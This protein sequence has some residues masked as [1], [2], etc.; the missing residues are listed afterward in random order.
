VRRRFFRDSA[1][2]GIASF[3]SRGISVLLVPVYTRLLAPSDY[4]AIDVLTVVA[5]LVYVTVALEVA[6][7]LARNFPEAIDEDARVAYAS[8]AL[9]FS[10]AAYASFAII[11]MLATPFISAELLGR[12]GL[13]GVISIAIAATSVNGVFLLVQNQLRWQL[14]PRRYAIASLV[15]TVVS[16]S[17]SVA[18]V[19]ALH[20]GVAGVFFGQLLGAIAGIVVG[21]TFVRRRYRL[22]FDRKRLGE[23]LRFSL[24][25]VPSSIGVIVMLFVDRIAITALMT[26]ADVGLFGIGYRL[27]SLMSL[28]TVGFQT[29]LTPLIYMHHR[30]PETPAHLAQVFRVFLVVALLTSLVLGLFANEAVI[31]FTTPAYYGGAVVVPLLAPA[32]VLATMYIF[33]PGLAIARRTGVTAAINIGGGILNAGLNVILIP[34]AGILGA[35]G[36]TL[37]CNLLVFAAYMVLSQRHY[38]VPHRWRPIGLATLTTAVLLLVVSGLS[39]GWWP[40]ILVK[41]GAVAVAAGSFVVLGLIRP[42]DV[43]GPKGLRLLRR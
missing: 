18:F 12:P 11:A 36:A 14:D 34:I 10:V 37:T 26:L 6:Q 2:Y 22:I 16:A 35:A 39:I 41:S 20:L 30:E 7:G 5:S 17:G 21:G 31:L 27:A 4:G 13:E 19:A 9:W 43:R 42:S 32:I 33:A 24:P 8:T 3:L 23:M 29:S 1:I 40:T 28:V 25:L 38:P 15:F